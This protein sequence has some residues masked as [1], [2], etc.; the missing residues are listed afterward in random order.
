MRKHHFRRSAGLGL[1]AVLL[2]GALPGRAM[3]AQTHNT[4][5]TLTELTAEHITLDQTSFSHTGSEIRPNV[6]V[7]VEEQLLTLD[8]DYTL[9]YTDNVDVGQAAVVVTGIATASETQG[10]T[11]T[12]EVPFTITEAQTQPEETLPEKQPLELT[13]DHVTMEQTEFAYTG[14]PVEP[15]VTVT[16]E[17]ISLEKDRHFALEYVNNLLPGT[18]TAIIRGID[19][20][21]QDQG[22]T[23]EVRLDFTILAATEDTYPLVELKQE[24]VT[25]KGMVFPHT[26]KPIEPEI[27]VTVE[28]KTLVKDRDYSL[29]YENNVDIGTGKAIVRGIATATEQ[30]GYTGTVEVAFSIRAAEPVK[31]TAEHIALEGTR[32]YHTGKPIEPKV[33]VTVEGKTLVKDRDYTLTYEN[34][35]LSG[36]AGVTVTG[37]EEAGFTGSVKLTFTIVPNYTITAGSGARWYRES[38]KSL[39]FTADGSY[40]SFT[41]VSVDGKRLDTGWFSVSGNTVV[42][43]K[44]SLL[45]KLSIGEH[46]VTVH[47]ADGDAQGTFR[48]LAG[49]DPTNPETGDTLPLHALAA[50]MFISLTGLIGLGYVAAKKRRK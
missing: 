32:F 3:A 14:S 25:I 7:R 8:Q 45:K 19:P 10:Y 23:G 16:V 46:T 40:D 49:L 43:L 34:N 29:T 47:F 39:R 31:L 13:A 6:T 37:V 18:G 42:T 44:N 2:L 26:G 24:H 11:G 35:I 33:T 22:Y 48:V 28:G 30:G 38:T 4:E 5:F 20:Q 21:T 36:T 41:G 27:T 15:Q 12:V 1:C 50:A 9:S 17:G